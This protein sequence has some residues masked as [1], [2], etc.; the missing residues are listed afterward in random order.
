MLWSQ[1]SSNDKIHLVVGL[2][3]VEVML[4]GSAILTLSEECLCEWCVCSAIPGD[5]IVFLRAEDKP[6]L[7]DRVIQR[8]VLRADCEINKPCSQ[9]RPWRE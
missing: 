6:T 2:R 3:L 8:V 1:P 4:L 9:P 7:N 5:A